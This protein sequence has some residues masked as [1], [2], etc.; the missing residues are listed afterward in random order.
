MAEVFAAHDERLD[1]VVAVKVIAAHLEDRERAERHFAREVLAI[2]GLQHP[3]VVS[4]YDADVDHDQPYLVTELV[5]GGNLAERIADGPLAPAEAATIAAEVAAGLGA[6]HERGLI[7]R[8]VKPAN[9]LL[10]SDGTAKVTDFGIVRALDR[11]AT[12]T[13]SVYGSTPYVA[14]EQ[15]RGK[16]ADERTD[17]YALGCLL[18][19][20]L[21]GRPP[22]VGDTP[23][24]V[25]GQHLQSPVPNVAEVRPEALEPLPGDLAR[26]VT[27]CLA[28]DP[29]A[30]P[31][32]MRDVAAALP[33]TGGAGL[34]ATQL[35]ENATT[36]ALPDEAEVGAP[37]GAVA[38]ETDETPD[39]PGPTIAF[40]PA[41]GASATGSGTGDPRRSR[42]PAIL[43]GIVVIGIVW[44][45][46]PGGDDDVTPPV[47]D[48]VGE[49]DDETAAEPTEEPEPEPEQR[50]DAAEAIAAFQ[51][52]LEEGL[53]ADQ[54]KKK[55]A[56]KL[57]KGMEDVA[58][59]L[60]EGDEN[61]ALRKAAEL[62]EDLE[63]M[64]RSNKIDTELAD[65]LEDDLDAVL[66]ALVLDED[67]GDQGGDQN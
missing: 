55:E 14:P 17:V 50:M 37:V 19:E 8:D 40:P 2:A 52:H 59:K 7:H 18:F 29:G 34:A 53:A 25:I 10:T 56:E 58:K 12:A 63:D 16:E 67:D 28:K 21:A 31:A 39:P 33:S 30:R 45:L 66:Q 1:R 20:M 41:S 62:R 32:S 9:V 15:I 22:Y 6:A 60:D 27:R 35:L 42:W 51:D 23:A 26:L 64:R 13:T 5:E 61:E 54:L 57:E 38:P 46:A 11:T 44:A 49:G 24:G 36:M 3:N 65:Q 4:V 48:A 43:V 47:V